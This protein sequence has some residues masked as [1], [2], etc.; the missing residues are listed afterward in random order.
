MAALMVLAVNITV[1]SQ[2]PSLPGLIVPPYT[3]TAGMFI[4]AIAS[5]APGMFLSQPPTARTPS[6][7]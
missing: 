3:N 5:M 7:L 6:M 2:P 1:R 4:R